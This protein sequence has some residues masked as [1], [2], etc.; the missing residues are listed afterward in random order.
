MNNYPTSR[1]VIVESP[2]KCKKIE[3]FL[4][5]GYTC[6]ASY[7]HITTLQSLKDVDIKNHFK[8]R[9]KMIDSKRQNINKLEAY[10]KKSDEVILATDDDREGEAIA[11]HICQQF[12]LPVATTKRI[13][14]HE[15]TKPAL[16]RAVQQPT[17]IN[18]NVVH[19]QQARQILDII[20]GFKLSPLL[21]AHISRKTKTGLSAGRC[22][23]P[24]LRIIYENQKD[25]DKSPGKMV[26]TTTGYFTQHHLP[27]VLNHE[28]TEQSKIEEFLE[29]SVG[30]DYLY[31]CGKTRNTTKNPPRPFTTSR[32]QQTAN[33]ELRCSPKDTMAIC[34]KLYEGGFIT[35]MRT[36]SETYS[37]EFLDIAKN[38]ITNKW[39]ENYVMSSLETMGE[40]KKGKAKK[41]K[42]EDTNN[43]QEAHEAIRPTEI[44]RLEIPENFSAKERKMYGLIWRNTVESCMAVAKYNAVTASISAPFEKEYRYSTEQVVFPGWKTVAG[45]EKENS[46][47]AFLKALKNVDSYKKVVSKVTLKELKQ[48]YTEA[49]LVQ[50]L[51][52]KGIG[53]PST[54][55]SLI[56]KIQERGYVKRDNIK[57]KSINCVDFELEGEE[58]NEIEHSRE[59]GN[60]KNKLVI[61]SVGIM[62]IEF[63]LQ[64]FPKFFDY[65]YSKDM[66]NQLDLIAKN[67]MIWYKLC[68]SCLTDIEGT[69]CIQERKQYPI[70]D[71]HIY[72]IGKYG[73]VIKYTDDQGENV[74]FKN[75][76][77]D[78]DMNKLENGEYTLKDIL[79]VDDSRGLGEI[80]GKRV[81]IKKGKY[82]HYADIEGK[83]VSLQK[84]NKPVIDITI[85]DIKS[86]LTNKDILR[87]VT[88]YISLR[89]SKY[90]QYLY[91]KTP[92][93]KTPEFISIKNMK[94]DAQTCNIDLIIDYVNTKKKK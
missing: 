32:L 55:A 72:M 15:I 66:E 88:E 5:A 91:Y 23:T 83:T 27:F 35:Y 78:I 41:G 31:A 63:L 20:V 71:N 61:Q 26:Y 59:F 64:H 70:D 25:I 9:F 53:R 33:T 24:A 85:D 2:A 49:K 84:L 6:L 19:A 51:E 38:Y 54:F 46:V 12:G 67:E 37:K 7:G 48:H 81:I 44:T 82:G 56:E 21:W 87:E 1:L 43:A 16:Q 11:W 79:L 65:G 68:E 58:L 4:G 52:E 3:S 29:E 80:D 28:F 90:G 39:G 45:Y 30:F 76:K 60:E 47:F 34:Q 13:I 57:G 14:F 94:E 42:K 50:I 62:V 75:V 8:P 92:S 17:I 10:I 22:Q 69:P 89:K 18:M 73:P 86:L 77:K 93:H 40:K 74:K 36:D